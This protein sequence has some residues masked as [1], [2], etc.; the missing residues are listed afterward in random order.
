[1]SMTEKKSGKR[2]KLAVWRVWVQLGFL[3][4][5]LDPLLLRM[6][7][8]CGPVFHCYSCPLAT[9]LCPIGVLANFSALHAIPYAAIGT[10]VALGAVFGSF[11]CGWVCP[12]GFLQDLIAK[13]PT[14]KFV[15]PA[16]MGSIRYVVLAAFVVVIPY[17]WGEGSSLFFCRLCPAGAIEGSLPNMA[18]L[19]MAGQPMV[20]PTAVK[21]TILIAVV[22]AM[23]FMWRPWCT[24]FCPL[25]AIYAMMNHVSFVFLRFHP[26]LCAGC[27]DCRSLCRD[28]REAE[29]RVDGM[30]CVRCLECTNCRSVTMETVLSRSDR[31]HGKDVPPPEIPMGTA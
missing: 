2:A 23:F 15:A 14:R 19:A 22:I 17:L 8:I 27:A 3:A 25:G 5:W 13:V 29:G 20:W 6:H 16:W 26:N 1:M 18:Q 24:L 9:F 10:L 7:N 11:I 30:R 28:S 12:F 31:P 21:M 4:V